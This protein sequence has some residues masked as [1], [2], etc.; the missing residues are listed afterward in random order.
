MLTPAISSAHQNE[1]PNYGW[2]IGLLVLPIIVIPLLILGWQQSR[3]IRLDAIN[4][5]LD[6][7]GKLRPEIEIANK[8]K[9]A[10]LETILL[11]STVLAEAVDANWLGE[12]RATVEIRVRYHY[13]IDL[14]K[15][16]AERFTYLPGKNIL[17]AT[18]PHATRSFDF[19]D[20][21]PIREE[22]ATGWLRFRS[23]SGAQQLL[24]AY[25]K[26]NSEAERKVL[27]DDE[28]QRVESDSLDRV[29]ELIQNLVESGTTVNVQ[30][31]D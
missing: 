30:Y 11:D 26:L 1:M 15:L 27:P 6:D 21:E 16:N 18:I 25:K 31:E 23:M 2:R 14:E 10:R 17:T 13:A 7:K 29:R 9:A 8:V 20:A 22:I 24:V 5:N 19:P 4:R 3:A 12:T 28:L